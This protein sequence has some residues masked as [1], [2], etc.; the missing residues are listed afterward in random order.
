MASQR[1]SANVASLSALYRTVLAERKLLVVLDNARDSEQVIPLLPGSSN[2]LVLVT[3]RSR[4]SGLVAS[5]GA[6][7]VVLD[8]LSMAESREFLRC[9]LGAERVAN[10]PDAIRDIVTLTGG[11]PLALAIV[12]AHAA[13]RPRFLL[14]TIADELS[15]FRDSLDAFSDIDGL[16]DLRAVF[17]WSY[18]ALSVPAARLFRLLALCPGTSTTVFAAAS[19]VGLSFRVT[20]ALLRELDAASL[21]VESAPSRYACHDLLR[22]YA[23][24][25]VQEE[26]TETEQRA[27]L[28]RLLDH[29]L[30]TVYR[31]QLHLSQQLDMF[32]VPEF[33]DGVLPYEPVS[34]DTAMAWLT[35]EYPALLMVINWADS[36]GFSRHVWQ[37]AW[38]IRHFQNRQTYWRD[39]RTVQDLALSAARRS[40]DQL[41]MA[42]AH[43]GVAAAKSQM[44]WSAS[45]ADSNA[46]IEHV[47]EALA[48]FGSAG[49]D[50]TLAFTHRQLSGLFRLHGDCVSSVSAAERALALFRSVGEPMGEALAL[51]AIGEA[52]TELGQAD[53]ALSY[54]RQ[55]LSIAERIGATYL[56]AGTWEDVGYAYEQFGQY[57]EA[58]DGYERAV[59]IYRTTGGFRLPQTLDSLARVYAAMDRTEEADAAIADSDAI[60]TKFGWH[61]IPPRI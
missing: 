55:C 14:S 10:E 9:R 57:G 28:H 33:V 43:R 29:Y 6:H 2:S 18:R 7:R 8:A 40:D 53:E 19:L 44:G 51:N 17:S 13:G 32:A 48:L 59:E 41:G 31:A 30:H 42:Y 21:W 45:Q 25:L 60:K 35:L 54:L 12:A 3:S 39:L 23:T 27:A 20:R 11:L 34:L 46:S 15:A 50:L 47:R 56:C 37:M 24:E 26:E 22:L 49:D 52:K 38:C 58:V 16:T 1:S 61:D 4:L 36:G 5:T